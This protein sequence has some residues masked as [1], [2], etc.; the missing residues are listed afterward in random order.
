MDALTFI[1]LLSS[2]LLAVLAAYA[3]MG[4]W[5]RDGV[6]IKTGLIAMSMGHALVA[7]QVF[8]G[9]DCGDMLYINRARTLAN[10]GLLLV[11][12]G[13][14]W[15]HYRGERLRDILPHVF[16]AARRD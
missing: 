3:V 2:A 15:R 12:A 7:L 4:H 1:N 10:A 13:Y 5:V 6:V 9:I 11:L 14:A 16:S 8:D